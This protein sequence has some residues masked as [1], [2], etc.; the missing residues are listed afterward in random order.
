[1][2][3]SP[4]TFLVTGRSADTDPPCSAL[5]AFR[6]AEIHLVGNGTNDNSAVGDIVRANE[7]VLGR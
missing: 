7:D 6:M 2:T 1:M 3:M 5:T 4:L